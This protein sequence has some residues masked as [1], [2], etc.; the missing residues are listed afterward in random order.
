MWS[1]YE[2][3]NQKV[4]NFKPQEFDKSQIKK[5]NIKEVFHK[6]VM[7]H[8]SYSNFKITDNV[9]AWAQ[10]TNENNTRFLSYESK[11]SFKYKLIHSI[12]KIIGRKY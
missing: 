2:I 9:L 11:A 3:I 4:P 10:K 6:L 5:P 7:Q 8:P 1:D 12:K